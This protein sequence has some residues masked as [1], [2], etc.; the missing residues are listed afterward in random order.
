M[1]RP[2]QHQLIIMR[3][4]REKAQLERLL[5]AGGL[6]VTDVTELQE[7][8][9]DLIQVEEKARALRE[10]IEALLAKVRDDADQP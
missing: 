5:G 2:T 6:E 7:I 1:N 4:E 8:A 10:R 3:L 9:A